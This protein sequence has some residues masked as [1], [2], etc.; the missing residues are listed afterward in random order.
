MGLLQRADEGI[1]PYRDAA[2]LRVGAD[3]HIRPLVQTP[4]NHRPAAAK[5][6]AIQCDDHPDKVG[7]IRHGAAVLTSQKT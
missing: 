4:I 6:E 3:A 1:G 2:D 5:R 7:T